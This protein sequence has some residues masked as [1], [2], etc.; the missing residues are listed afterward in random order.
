MRRPVPA[1]RPHFVIVA[2]KQQDDDDTRYQHKT[3]GSIR[4]QI[5][6]RI[7]A[8]IIIMSKKRS[9]ASL[10][11]VV[12]LLCVLLLLLL[13]K[14]SCSLDENFT[15]A[16]DDDDNYNNNN[17][18]GGGQS[19]RSNISSLESLSSAPFKRN[20]MTENQLQ[21]L[22]R[23]S[24]VCRA[25]SP[26]RQAESQLPTLEEAFH[27]D[28]VVIAGTK[29]NKNDASNH[30]SSPSQHHQHR[31]G[32]CHS[33]NSCGS[34]SKYHSPWDNLDE[35]VLPDNF[36]AVFDKLFDS[37]SDTR[38]ARASGTGKH[39]YYSRADASPLSIEM[40]KIR[41]STAKRVYLSFQDPLLVQALTSQGLEGHLL[42]SNLLK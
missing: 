35:V 38:V 39:H 16:N 40:E 1:W 13:G 5:L 29:I 24:S 22:K 26:R 3:N 18:G 19:S 9:K 34:R 23:M 27:R 42:Q 31:Q 6:F 28:V 30:S 15:T 37:I 33:N 2:S 4:R 8:K 21:F 20:G 41:E 36:K 11:L 12:T 25:E 17:N 32:N 7:R 14:S 10:L